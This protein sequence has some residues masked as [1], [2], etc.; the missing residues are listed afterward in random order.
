M[1]QLF[2]SPLKIQEQINAYTDN[3][4]LL[5]GLKCNILNWC[6]YLYFF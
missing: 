5:N 6:I 2:M 3:L 4:K 1:F